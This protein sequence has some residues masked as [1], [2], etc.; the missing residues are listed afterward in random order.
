MALTT[1]SL[2]SVL[3]D[4]DNYLVDEFYKTK[5]KSN[6]KGSLL[7]KPSSFFDITDDKFRIQILVPGHSKEQLKI[8][9]NGDKVVV[10]A[11]V[12]E[13]EKKTYVKNFKIDFYAPSDIWDHSNVEASLESG[14]LTISLSRKEKKE[15]THTVVIK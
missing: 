12:P 2:L 4:I 15:N 5:E 1:S 10:S 14:V 7:N 11:A 9:P 13:D 3:N 8:E 6:L